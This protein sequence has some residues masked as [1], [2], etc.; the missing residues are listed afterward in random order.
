MLKVDVQKKYKLPKVGIG[1]A[2]QLSIGG[3]KLNG[4][5][6]QNGNG[7]SLLCFNDLFTPSLLGRWTAGNS[8]YHVLI[9]YDAQILINILSEDY[10]H[11]EKLKSMT[12]KVT[13]E[14]D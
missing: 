9:A 13:E 10:G 4:I 8:E 14:E 3:T 7:C 5:I 11:V 6:V 2:I 12:I 1:D